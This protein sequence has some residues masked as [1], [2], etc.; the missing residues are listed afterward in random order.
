MHYIDYASFYE[1]ARDKFLGRLANMIDN[2]QRKHQLD[3]E[4]H[5]RAANRLGESAA[6]V[7]AQLQ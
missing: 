6:R 5:R 4:F 3:S 7:E 2:K 1:G